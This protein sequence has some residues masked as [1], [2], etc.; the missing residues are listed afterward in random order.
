MTIP[1][2][3]QPHSLTASG[4]GRWLDRIVDLGN[5]REIVLE[6]G[7]VVVKNLNFTEPEFREFVEGLGEKVSYEQDD[8]DVGYGF[9]DILH[10]NGNREIG[11]V[12]TG[13]SGLPLHTDGILLGTQVDFI[14]LFATKA[15][16]LTSDGATLVC[17]QITAWHEMPNDLR[18]VLLQG[19]LEYLANERGYF[20]N[21]PDNWYAIPTFRNYGRVKS[22]NIALPFLDDAPTSWSVRIPGVP[23]DVS[24]RFFDDLRDHFMQERYLYEHYWSTGDLVVIDNQR[25]LHGRR[26]LDREGIRVLLRG[27]VTLPTIAHAPGP[28][29]SIL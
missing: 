4:L 10:L 28:I 21:V 16:N 17:D 25:T 11:K 2:Y 6:S 26:G 13:R 24:V 8:A 22:L 12:I 19:Q 18:D 29:S 23:T 27:Q 7:A 20:T 14:I 15:E 9:T 3:S 5:L 1:L